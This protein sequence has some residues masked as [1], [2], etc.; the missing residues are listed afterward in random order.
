MLF[1]IANRRHDVALLVWA[2]L[3]QAWNGTEG[4]TFLVCNDAPPLRSPT[5]YV[6]WVKFHTHFVCVF[7]GLVIV[8]PPLRP[9]APALLPTPPFLETKPPSDRG[10]RHRSFSQNVRGPRVLPVQRAAG[11]IGKLPRA[12]DAG[13]HAAGPGATNRKVC[14]LTLHS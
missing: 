7:P 13:G 8:K 10:G 2:L 6:V 5:I 12:C 3:Q 11:S 4:E 14:S 9:P 1:P